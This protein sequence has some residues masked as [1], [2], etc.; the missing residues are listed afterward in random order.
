[1]GA[2]WRRDTYR[3]YNGYVIEREGK[4]ILFGGDTA[5]SDSF[6]E[7]RDKG[8]FEIAIMPIGAY[9]PWIC[10]HCTPEQAVAMANAAGAKYFV[11]IHHRTFHLGREGPIEPF[12][13]LR[14]ALCHE[15][16][17]IALG[18]IGETFSVT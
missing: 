15:P 1:M 2:R 13:R 12:E 11:P 10:S 18:E 4:K 14:T 5:F 17:R 16:E 3:G 6:A 8:P 7:L 9:R